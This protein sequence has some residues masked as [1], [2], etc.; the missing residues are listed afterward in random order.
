MDCSHCGTSYAFED[1]FCRQ[2]GALLS[3]NLPAPL[4]MPGIPTQYHSERPPLWLAVATVA[5]GLALEALASRGLGWVTMKA[6]SGLLPAR[7][8]KTPVE[9][10]ETREEILQRI[11]VLIW[12]RTVTKR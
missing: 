2:C 1:N 10:V 8:A 5:T 12:R 3:A 6:R 9:R 11:E 4:P 7:R